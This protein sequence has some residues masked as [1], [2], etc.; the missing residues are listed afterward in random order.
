MWVLQQVFGMEDKYL[1]CAP[2]E[3]AGKQLLDE[4][5]LAGNFGK[6]DT[7]INRNNRN[8]LLPR[9]FNYIKRNIR[10]VTGYPKEILFE[11]PMRTY[12]YIWKHFV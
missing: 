12:M 10:F 7:R 3:K 5:M 6:Y 11:I 4:V 9:I 1:L 8:K 2:H